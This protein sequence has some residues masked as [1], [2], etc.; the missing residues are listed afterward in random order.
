M[1]ITWVFG[2]GF[3]GFALLCL[4]GLVPAIHAAGLRHAQVQRLG[5]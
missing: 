1:V 5:R 3:D 2:L 4:A